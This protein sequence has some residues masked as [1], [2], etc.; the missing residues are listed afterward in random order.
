MS[1]PNAENLA[2]MLDRFDLSTAL[3][4]DW[5]VKWDVTDLL[6]KYK[7]ET[8][9]NQLQPEQLLALEDRLVDWFKRRMR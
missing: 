6:H 1:D 2:E 7:R 4:V 5:M 3:E 8:P 9:K